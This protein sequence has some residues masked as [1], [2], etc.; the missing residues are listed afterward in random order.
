MSVLVGVV[1]AVDEV[2]T[3]QGQVTTEP[4]VRLTDAV[5][6]EPFAVAVTTT[7]AEA[8]TVPAV[9]VNVAEVAE[10][11]TVT[12]AGTT[13]MVLL[14]ESVTARPDDGA[15]PLSWTVQ[16]VLAPEASAVGEQVREL[17]VIVDS[18]P[19]VR[20]AVWEA[21]FS[22]AV[23]TADWLLETVPAFA[24]KVAVEAPA[25]T[26]TEVGA[27]SSVELLASVTAWPPVGAAADRVTV[28]VEELPEVRLV[29][30]QVR[31]L[32]TVAA[33]MVTEAVLDV[34]FVVAVTVT[35]V[36]AVTAKAATV[37]LDV[38]EKVAVEDPAG[39]VTL[40]GTVRAVLLSAMVTI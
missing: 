5:L 3:E 26:V 7:V 6:E 39:T 23:R 14:S 19:S 1:G 18:G 31:L 32:T 17:T 36:V 11:A 28:Q 33:A 29:G 24:V 27:V 40:L 38:A 34:P 12:E 10:A 22:V 35:A 8:V 30:L 13:R 20:V 2:Q 37:V 4:A 16:V 15:A 21:P 25:A 9:A